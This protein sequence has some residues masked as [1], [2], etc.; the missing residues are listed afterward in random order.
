[1]AKPNFQE[2]ALNPSRW[3]A[4]GPQLAPPLKLQEGRQHPLRQQN[5]I[6]NKRQLRASNKPSHSREDG[7]LHGKKGLV[8]AMGVGKLIQT[9]VICSR[10]QKFSR[11]PK[12]PALVVTFIPWACAAAAFLIATIFVTFVMWPGLGSLRTPA[13]IKFSLLPKRISKG[14]QGIGNAMGRCIGYCLIQCEVRISR[15]L[16][17]RQERQTRNAPSL[18]PTNA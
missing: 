2:G 4:P 12:L 15:P 16:P 13:A 8:H 17:N 18:R 11:Q 7:M 10:P 6:R 9:A 14:R 1:M 5:G 3:E